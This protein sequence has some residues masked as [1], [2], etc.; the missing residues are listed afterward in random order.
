MSPLFR[1]NCHPVSCPSL[2]IPVA[3]PH[4]CLCHLASHTSPLTPTPLLSCPP[5]TLIPAI[6]GLSQNVQNPWYQYHCT[7]NPVW[8]PQP[9]PSDLVPCSTI[10][11]FH[12]C[13]LFHALCL[14]ISYFTLDCLTSVIVRPLWYPLCLWSLP[15]MATS[16]R[17]CSLISVCPSL[18]LSLFVP[19]VQVVC[20]TSRHAHDLLFNFSLL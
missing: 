1:P 8:S 10:Y 19:H 16:S 6:L 14:L 5:V 12:D 4:A 20:W 13:L 2:P 15:C 3:P 11:L 17:Y 18:W 9:R 7:L